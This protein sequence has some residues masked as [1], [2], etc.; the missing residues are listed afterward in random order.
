M[1]P[2]KYLLRARAVKPKRRITGIFDSLPRSG[3][4]VGANVSRPL[5]QVKDWEEALE[6]ENASPYGNAASVYTSSGAAADF[7]QMR[8]RAGMIGERR[9]GELVACSS[10][11]NPL[12]AELWST[13]VELTRGGAPW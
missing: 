4:V 2:R 12:R 1:S 5:R 13:G 11:L 8:F 9:P 7:F 10:G 6:V 3:P